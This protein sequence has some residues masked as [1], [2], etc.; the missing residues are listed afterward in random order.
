METYFENREADIGRF[1][2][3]HLGERGPEV[4]RVFRSAAT[5]LAVSVLARGWERLSSTA[6]RLGVSLPEH[7][8]WEVGVATAPVLSGGLADEPFLNLLMSENPK[9]TAGW[10]VWLYS[11]AF[12]DRDS[13]PRVY[14]DGWEM[15]V[16]P[17][18]GTFLR[19]EDFWRLEPQ[20]RFYLHRALQDD[21]RESNRAPEPSTQLDLVL[22][23]RRTAETSATALAFA[24]ALGADDDATLRF[25]FRWRGL[26]GRILATWSSPGR[27]LFRNY[28]ALQNEVTTRLTVP[29][30]TP[31]SAI[32]PHVQAATAPL[33]AAFDGATID[34]SDVEELLREML[35]I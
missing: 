35:N 11:R 24:R 1:L 5:D 8:A 29:V 10:P 28:Q 4:E 22:V 34:M 7:G 26:E 13:H 31:P 12:R 18:S 14:E 21:M 33:F 16:R 19:D 6:E 9:Y 20:G 3:R 15:L 30:D 25:A 27:H 17:L 23:I 32:G 2:R